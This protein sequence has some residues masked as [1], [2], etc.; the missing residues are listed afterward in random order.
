MKRL[1]AM[2]APA[3]LSCLLYGVA[4]A[5]PAEDRMTLGQAER[6]AIDL[7][8]GMTPDE[9]QKLLGKPNR[10]ALKASG[11]GAAA[12]SPQGTLHWTYTWS[13]PSQ[14][15]RNLQVTFISKSPD[16]WLVN[17]WDWSNY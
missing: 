12:E 7:K 5:A 9:V 8:Q 4:T 15:A 2:L 16:Q 17:A 10:T 1:Y 3:V 6:H 11:Y 13:S 14:S